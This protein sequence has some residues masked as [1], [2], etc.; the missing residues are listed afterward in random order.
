MSKCAQSTTNIIMKKS[1]LALILGLILSISHVAVPLSYATYSGRSMGYQDYRY[2][3]RFHD[4]NLNQ[5]EDIYINGNDRIKLLN[6]INY[7]RSSKKTYNY[8]Y[9]GSQLPRVWSCNWVYKKYPSGWY[10]EKDYQPTY[11]LYNHYPVS[12]GYGY[13][14]NYGRTACVKIY[15]PAHSHY[16]ERGDG[17]ECDPGYRP[18][19]AQTTCV[20]DQ[21]TPTHYNHVPYHNQYNPYYAYCMLNY[22][23]HPKVDC[24]RVY[25]L[26]Y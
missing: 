26:G 11:Q 17:W 7:A 15:K 10:C 13:K 4:Y 19:Y 16:S 21:Y 2:Y 20:Y 25:N 18:N 22:S 12:C 24:G 8:E 6:S 23:N 14:L 3:D 5:A 1:V 9:K